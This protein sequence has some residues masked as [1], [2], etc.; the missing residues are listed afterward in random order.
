M[1]NTQDFIDGYWEE[2]EETKIIKE[3]YQKEYDIL[4][5]KKIDNKIIMTI[6]IILFIIREHKELLD[7]LLM[8]IKKAKIFIQK[9]TN[10]TYENLIKE[11]QLK[12][13]KI[14]VKY[15]EFTMS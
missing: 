11:I 6:L 12:N 2:N 4:K 15:K 3:K 14:K 8:I 5:A 10:D 13:N 7:E 9:E 1:I